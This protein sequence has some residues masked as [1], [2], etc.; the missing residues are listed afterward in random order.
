[1]DIPFLTLNISK[2]S[3]LWYKKVIEDGKEINTGLSLLMPEIF[4]YLYAPLEEEKEQDFKYKPLSVT[5]RKRLQMTPKKYLFCIKGIFQDK[6][7]QCSF[8][9]KALASLSFT[10]LSIGD[11]L[12]YPGLIAVISDKQRYVIAKNNAAASLQKNKEQIQKEVEA[13]TA[14]LYQKLLDAKILSPEKH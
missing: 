13:W 1:M 6:Y 14:N 4:P 12:F 10:F 8:F 7:Y 5:L 3:C 2:P 9:D 11:M